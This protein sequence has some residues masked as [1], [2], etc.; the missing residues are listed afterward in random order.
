MEGGR[1]INGQDLIPFFGRKS[2]QG[3]DVLDT[4][5]VDEDVEPAVLEERRADHVANGRGLGHVGGRIADLHA[6]FPGKVIPGLGDLIDG[7]KAVQHD[8]GTG[9]RECTSDAKADS[10]GGAG[11]ERDLA[12]KHWRTFLVRFQLDVHSFEPSIGESCRSRMARNLHV[13][14]DQ[15]KYPLASETIGPR[16]GARVYSCH[17]SSAR[18]H[19]SKGSLTM[20]MH[21]V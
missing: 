18:L 9:P 6:V 13:P 12:G 7:A 19:R 5:I 15:R 8:R 1:Q 20:E 3:R 21:Q 10:A 16:Y 17:H 4:S 14:R 11:H 2:L